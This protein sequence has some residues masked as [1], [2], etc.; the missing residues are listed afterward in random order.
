MGMKGSAY[1]P[2]FHVY[3]WKAACSLCN[4]QRIY[5]AQN[6]LTVIDSVQHDHPEH[7]FCIDIIMK[8]G[9]VKF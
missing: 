3:E 8:F 9:K 4:W 2:G 5:N 6:K 1:E 7:Q